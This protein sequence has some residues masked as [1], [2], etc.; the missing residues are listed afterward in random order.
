MVLEQ[1]DIDLSAGIRLHY[2]LGKNDK[3]AKIV[4]NSD[5]IWEEIF[6]YQEIQ[7]PE[8]N[9]P[10][11]EYLKRILD[12]MR[13]GFILKYDHNCVGLRVSRLC[14]SHIFIA[15]T[16]RGPPYPKLE[17]QTMEMAYDVGEC[18][19]N[20]PG[21]PQDDCVYFSCGVKPKNKPVESLVGE[22]GVWVKVR[23]QGAMYLNQFSEEKKQ[24]MSLCFS[25]VTPLEDL[26]KKVSFNN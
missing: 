8:S 10:S 21:Q 2:K 6:K 1:K 17:K 9:D 7:L 16:D 4:T 11:A 22:K 13:L 3:T 5:P 19:R 26:I 25:N 23:S 24:S 12:G 15:T 14:Q 20:S 18:M